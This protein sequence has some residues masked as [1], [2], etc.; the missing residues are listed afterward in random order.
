[1]RAVLEALRYDPQAGARRPRQRYE[2]EVPEGATVL[3]ALMAIQD[4]QDGSL[5]FR[6]ACRHGICGSCAMR[7]NGCAALACTTQVAVAMAQAA[8]MAAFPATAG[9]GAGGAAAHHSSGSAIGDVEAIPPVR[10]EPLANMPPVKDL[11]VDMDVFWRKLRA[12]RPWLF[13]PSGSGAMPGPDEEFRVSPAQWDVFAQGVLCVECGACYSDCNSVTAEPAFVGPAAI[14]K[15]HRYAFDPRDVATHERV[16]DLSDEHGL[17]ECMRC[18][19]CTHRCP[20]HIRVRELIAQLGALAVREGLDADPGARHAAAFL[21]SL[22]STG[23]LNET[24][25]AVKSQGWAWAAQRLPMAVQIA[26]AGKLSLPPR[27]LPDHERLLRVMEAAQALE[28]GTPGN[29]LR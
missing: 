28:D 13:P 16:A 22:Q 24:D 9:G 11:V 2:V 6:R 27:P 8:R 15:A 29:E 26:L 23:R 20:K 10:L 12:R 18:Y 5:T 4:E 3:E 14:A 25:L 1:M 7:I 17:W 19:F 21:D